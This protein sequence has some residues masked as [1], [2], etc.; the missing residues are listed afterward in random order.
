MMILS[1]FLFRFSVL[2][3]FFFPS[4]I[5]P[6]YVYIVSQLGCGMFLFTSLQVD[7]LHFYVKLKEKA[8]VKQVYLS[9]YIQY[10][11]FRLTY[12]ILKG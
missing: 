5:F 10:H 1:S 4:L 12:R 3:L 9:T 8:I 2:L 7:V 6:L 11:R